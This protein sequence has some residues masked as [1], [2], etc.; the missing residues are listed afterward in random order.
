MVLANVYPGNSSHCP[1]LGPSPRAARSSDSRSRVLPEASTTGEEIW[2]AIF[3]RSGSQ[4]NAKIRSIL[5]D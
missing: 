3:E 4:K 1:T 5:V 2:V